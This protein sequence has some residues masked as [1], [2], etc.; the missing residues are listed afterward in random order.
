MVD[1]QV[2]R[3]ACDHEDILADGRQAVV[4]GAKL[5]GAVSAADETLAGVL[6]R[7]SSS[8]MRSRRGGRIVAGVRGPSAS[9][10]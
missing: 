6:E 7:D 10:C 2:Q 9:G 1:A 8:T 4:T 3:S 5:P